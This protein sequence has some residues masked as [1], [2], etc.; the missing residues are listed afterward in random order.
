MYNCHDNLIK[1][2]ASR[3]QFL[4]FLRSGRSFRFEML[5]IITYYTYTL[6]SY[7]LYFDFLMSEGQSGLLRLNLA[8]TGE[9]FPEPWEDEL[10]S[11]RCV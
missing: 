6:F 2:Y 4:T 3:K 1:I 8:Y 9:V 5:S 11:R 7:Y 10:R